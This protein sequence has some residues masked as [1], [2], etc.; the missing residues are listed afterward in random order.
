[1]PQT[2]E[3]RPKGPPQH[4]LMSDGGGL[5]VNEQSL[6]HGTTKRGNVKIFWKKENERQIA[7]RRETDQCTVTRSYLFLHKFWFFSTIYY[8]GNWAFI[9]VFLIGLMVSCCKGKKSVIEG[10]VEA[11]DSDMSDEEYLH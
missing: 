7:L 4:L 10:E 3:R 1:M 2:S 6:K 5:K 8:F 11:D 9:G